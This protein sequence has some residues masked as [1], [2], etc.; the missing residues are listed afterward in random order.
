MEQLTTTNAVGEAIVNSKSVF[1]RM[2]KHQSELLIHLATNPN[3]TF[4][5][6]IELPFSIK[7]GLAHLKAHGV[8]YTDGALMLLACMSDRPGTMV[9]YCTVLKY[10][11]D[12]LGRAAT[13]DDL[14]S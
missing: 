5:K 6:N 7:V 1:R 13:V 12:K 11:A 4:P 9:L 2:D 10:L 8:P 3:F 14:C